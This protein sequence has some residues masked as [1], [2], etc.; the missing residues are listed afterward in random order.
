MSAERTRV[1]KRFTDTDGSLEGRIRKWLT[2]QTTAYGSRSLVS[3][4]IGQQR[5]WASDYIAGKIK[6]V[7]VDEAAKLLFLLDLLPGGVPADVAAELLLLR[8]AWPALSVGERASFL[9][10]IQHSAA[11][12]RRTTAESGRRIPSDTK[13]RS[14]RGRRARA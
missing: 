14:R 9:K 10:V 3:S 2:E 5:G 1:R 6:H 7:T 4:A 13:G 11:D 8:A 12:A